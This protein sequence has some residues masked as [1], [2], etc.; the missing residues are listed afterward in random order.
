MSFTPENMFFIG[1]VLIFA[2]IVISKWGYRFGIPTLLLFLFTGMIFGSDGLG[3]EFNSHEDAQLI[4]MLSLSI[5]LFS[6][7]MDT[8]FQDIRPVVGQGL[9]LSTLGVMLTT[10]ITGLLIYYLSEWTRLDIGLTLPMSMLLAATVSSTDSASVFNLLRSQGIGL[11]HNLRPILEL[12]SGSNDPMAYVLTISLVQMIVAAGE[13]SGLELATKIVGQLAVGGLLGYLSGLSLVWIVNHINL[14]NASLYPVLVLSSILIIFTFTDMLE[15]NGYL[16]VYV[17]GL[18]VGN[19]KL[20]YRRETNTFFQGITWL[21]Q[22][23][24]FLTLGLLADPSDMLDVLL[25]AVAI[26]LFMMFVARPLAVFLCLQPFKIPAKAK[27][28]LS[29]VGLR[30]AVP[31]I[32]ATYPVIAGI[33]D[34]H[35]LF[36]VVFVITL[37]SLSLQGTTISSCA[38][39]LGLATPAPKE[40]N[41]FGVEL[42][43]ELGSRLSEMVLGDADLANGNHLSDM[44]FPE[45]TLVMMIKRGNSI[46]VPNGRLELQKGDILLTIA[47]QS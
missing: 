40:G 34:A 23:V 20:S 33:E 46:I 10:G 43:D 32:F 8:K 36:N 37:L 12:E 35:F 11:K 4:G 3:L 6:G 17:A 26:G 38:R 42:P 7:G 13:F 27:L 25:V 15:G 21:L 39:W 18:V 47:Q 9:V 1:A 41:E 44:H 5:I 28:F 2:S 29:W 19:N 16:A 30:G 45:G 31:I 24:M 22:I 14:P